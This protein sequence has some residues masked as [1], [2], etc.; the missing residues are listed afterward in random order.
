MDQPRRPPPGLTAAAF[1]ESWLPEA[2][3]ASGSEAPDDAPLI[4]VSLSGPD[5]GDWHIAAEGTRLSVTATTGR[6]TAPG[7]EP[8]VWI[9][10]SA[11]DFL[12][13]FGGDADLPELLPAGWGP[14]DLLFL[15][16]RDVTLA[17][18]IAGRFLVEVAGKRRRRWALDLAFGTAGARAGRPRATVRLD[19]GLYDGLR[20]GTVAPLQALLERR[21]TVEGDR[22]LA[23]Q[24]LMLL[25]SRLARG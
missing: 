21:L 9:R 25:G 6:P 1:F 11:A 4:R 22:A 12:A 24:A 10:Q 17:R 2:Y 7:A 13:A 15:D 16:P 23:M 20:Q 3:T 5:G 19:G 18:Q 8:E 14:L